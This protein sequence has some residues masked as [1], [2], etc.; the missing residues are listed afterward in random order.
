[1]ARTV[2]AS[3]LAALATD[4]FR[5]PELVHIKLASGDVIALTNWDVALTVDLL[6]D[7]AIA[8]APNKI[9]G[10]SAFSAQINAPIDDSDLA[11]IIDGSTFI[12]DDIRRGM[13]DGAVV[14]VGYVLPTDLA[15][16]WL[17]RV[18]DVGQPSIEGL[19]ITLELMGP[20]KRLEQPVGRQLTANCPW[21]FGDLDCKLQIRANA[22][23]A[24]TVYALNTIVKRLTGTGIYWFKAT[25]AGTSA[26]SEPVWPA[27]GTVVDGTVTWTAIRARRL[28]GT[29]S[30]SANRRT[31]VA[32]GITVAGDYFGEGFLTFLT[33]DNAGDTR[34]VKTD[35]GT[36]TLTLHLSAFDDIAVGDTFEVIVGCRHRLTED[37]KTKH[38]NVVNFGGF[39]YLAEENVSMTAPKG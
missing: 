23:A 35:N 9:E 32:T 11:V 16:P 12:A 13:F 2:P 10:L 1:M 28:V 26:A 20:E 4:S 6:G 38:D 14:T 21:M 19:S 27:G 3:I 29:V 17:H 39:P 30:S 31:I 7:G 5:L 22:W 37:C 8:Y 36:G 18:Y 15:N 24:T 34:R 25:T 33:G